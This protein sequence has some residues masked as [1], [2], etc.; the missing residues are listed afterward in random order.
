MSEKRKEVS[1]VKNSWF[2]K[3]EKSVLGIILSWIFQAVIKVVVEFI[4]KT[5][6]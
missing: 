6:L 1:K 4:V 2:K 3:L 5:W